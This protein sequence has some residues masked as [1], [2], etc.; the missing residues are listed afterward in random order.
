MKAIASYPQSL[1]PLL[2][3]FLDFWKTR[4]RSF[5]H[6]CSHNLKLC[7]RLSF[8]RAHQRTCLLNLSQFQTTEMS[9]SIRVVCKITGTTHLTRQLSCQ[10]QTCS[11]FSSDQPAH[12]RKE[13]HM[14]VITVMQFSHALPNEKRIFEFV[15]LYEHVI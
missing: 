14:S 3:I 12:N 13:I 15:F 2:S 9:T 5:I 10:N 4:F 8:P 1:R 6:S 7:A 11:L